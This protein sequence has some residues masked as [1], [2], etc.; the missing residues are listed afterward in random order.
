MVIGMKIQDIKKLK[1]GDRVF[2]NDP[3]HGQCSRAYLIEM[4][5]IDNPER[6]RIEEKDGSVLEC[7]PA[8]LVPAKKYRAKVYWEMCSEVEVWARDKASGIAAAVEAPLPSSD[9]WEY[10]PDSANVDE[11]LDIHEIEA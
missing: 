7:P 8:E 2:W 5:R 4:I 6:I 1:R 9:T 3:D 10:V 11:E